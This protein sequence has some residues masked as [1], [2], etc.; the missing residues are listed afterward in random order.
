MLLEAILIHTQISVLR[1]ALPKHTNPGSRL[2][3]IVQ[4]E[5]NFCFVLAYLKGI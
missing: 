5:I 2:K 1:R 4:F 3:G